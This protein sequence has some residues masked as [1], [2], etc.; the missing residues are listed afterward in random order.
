ME[1]DCDEEACSEEAS[2]GVT[3]GRANALTARWMRGSWLREAEGGQRSCGWETQPLSS[4]GRTSRGLT[5]LAE[6]SGDGARDKA[7]GLKL[8]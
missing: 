5:L 2:S 4:T 6:R 3:C 8:R 1:N 7:P